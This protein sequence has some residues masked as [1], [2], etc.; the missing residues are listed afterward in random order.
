MHLHLLRGLLIIKNGPVKKASPEMG[1][2]REVDR[3]QGRNLK[4]EHV[5]G[6]V[7]WNSGTSRLAVSEKAVMVF[8]RTILGE[9]FIYLIKDQIT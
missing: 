2:E 3:H 9:Y 6:T 7:G 4:E 8:F 5:K 1:L